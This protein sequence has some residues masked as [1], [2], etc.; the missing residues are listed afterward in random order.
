MGFIDNDGVIGIQVSV[1]EGFCQK[2]A[3]GHYF[4]ESI[5]VGPVFESNLVSHRAPHLFPQFGGDTMSHGCGRNP[6]RLC[7][8][9]HCVDSATGLQ[10]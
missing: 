8:A 9:D 6:A 4:D 7:T 1:C 2:N 5:R 3:V 10:A